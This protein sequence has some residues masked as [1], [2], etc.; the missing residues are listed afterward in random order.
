MINIIIFRV[1]HDHG[2]TQNCY[3]NTDYL[4]KIIEV[5]PYYFV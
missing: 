5:Y 2:N 4:E 1:F 3:G